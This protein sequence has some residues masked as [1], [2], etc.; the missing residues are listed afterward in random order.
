MIAISRSWIKNM[1]LV[2]FSI[3]GTDKLNAARPYKVW[4]NRDS[5][6][7]L[8]ASARTLEQAQ[9]IVAIRQRMAS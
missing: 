8:V 4:D 5:A 3:T 1:D 2:D 6:S 7:I 9:S